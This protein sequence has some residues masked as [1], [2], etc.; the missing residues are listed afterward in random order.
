MKTPTILF[1]Y[2]QVYDNQW[3]KVWELRA[4][5]GEI[6]PKFPYPTREAIDNYI[7]ELEKLWKYNGKAI[8]EKIASI[9]TLPWKKDEISCY[10]VGRSQ[11]FSDPLTLAA[12]LEY[13]DYAIDVLTHEL[14]HQIYI[15][16]SH[17]LQN[18]W[19]FVD[20]KYKEPEATQVHIH[21]HAIHKKIYLDLFD[22]KHLERDIKHAQ[23]KQHSDA[24]KIVE[25]EGYE[26]LIK[27]FVYHLSPETT[28]K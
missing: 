4:K 27:E 24:W 21:V 26:N 17:R 15:Q 23:D 13:P 22:E 5:T 1:T 16:N 8:L 9:T 3:K 7:H 25:N 20:E 18:F 19:H 6:T 2:S 10:V 28:D 11:S 12:F 14:I